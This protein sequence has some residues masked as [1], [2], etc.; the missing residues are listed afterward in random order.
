MKLNEFDI[1]NI[2]ERFYSR[3]D[4]TGDCWLWDTPKSYRYG[5]F[6]I[7][8]NEKQAH[9]G[10]HRMA[11]LLKYG[12]IPD[13]LLVCHRCDT[14]MCVNPEHLF[15][16]TNKDNI[17]D[18]VVKGRFTTHNAKLTKPQLEEICLRRKRGETLQ[19]I[20]DLYGIS[21]GRIYQIVNKFG[22]PRLDNSGEHQG[23][24]KLTWKDVNEIRLQYNPHKIG[25]AQKLATEY[26]IYTYHIY[27]IWNNEIWKD[28]AYT[29]PTLLQHHKWTEEEV[30]DVRSRRE[31]GESLRFIAESYGISGEAKLK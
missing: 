14:P 3:I 17:H 31:K 2:V 10:V 30:V 26:D 13:G 28:P 8:R 7:K 4:K 18:C 15:L 23:R 24:S 12:E 21:Q 29:P 27:K 11:Y 16:G 5:M 25:N 1:S 19:A 22:C 9:I 20:A 6:Y